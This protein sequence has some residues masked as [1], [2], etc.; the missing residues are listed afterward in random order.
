MRHRLVAPG[1]EWLVPFAET[2]I[3]VLLGLGSPYADQSFEVNGYTIRVQVT[4]GHEYIRIEGGERGYIVLPAVGINTPTDGNEDGTSNLFELRVSSAGGVG[5]NKTKKLAGPIDW[6]GKNCVITYDHGMES[7]YRLSKTDQ[8]T[9]KAKPD[10]YKDGKK[11]PTDDIKVCG[12]AMFSGTYV[13]ISN[14]DLYTSVAYARMNEVWEEIGRVSVLGVTAKWS[15]IP[16]YTPVQVDVRSPWFFNKSGDKGVTVAYASYALSLAKA[17][18]VTI[19]KG[20]DGKLLAVFSIDEN[21]IGSLTNNSNTIV[22]TEYTRVVT[23]TF[24]Q[25]LHGVATLYDRTKVYYDNTKT[26]NAYTDFGSWYSRIGD[27]SDKNESVLAIDYADDGSELVVSVKYNA[28]ARYEKRITSGPFFN[29]DPPIATTNN[30]PQDP[31]ASYAIVGYDWSPPFSIQKTTVDER[32]GFSGGLYIQVNGTPIVSLKLEGHSEY[33]TVHDGSWEISS[34]ESI[35]EGAAQDIYQPRI[36]L[37]D[38]DARNKSAIYELYE[39]RGKKIATDSIDVLFGTYELD[40]DVS[41]VCVFEGAEV[42]R[43]PV[44]KYPTFYKMFHVRTISEFCASRAI[45]MR[46]GFS[47]VNQYVMTDWR[48]NE[49][50]LFAEVRS[51]DMLYPGDGDFLRRVSA[52]SRKKNEWVASLYV[53]YSKTASF[54]GNILVV[55]ENKE[56]CTPLI[57]YNAKDAV[58]G[59][60]SPKEVPQKQLLN[61]EKYTPESKFSMGPVKLW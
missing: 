51:T 35:T 34:V 60:R 17:V 28:G 47:V 14:T 25:T 6:K 53:R 4:P 31:H 20:E 16:S 41:L 3:K 7:R 11:I 40:C 45:P 2:R 38:V 15:L 36:A 24:V 22:P 12:A 49:I 59:A 1:C 13:I 27:G 21:Q 58:T 9:T 43:Y 30:A 61:I 48:F 37:Y 50:G 54:L 56:V 10:I 57:I 52:A 19:S 26:Y 32:Y 8:D 42:K 23:G 33:T 44:W 39:L 5:T 55:G 46:H 18:R 29:A